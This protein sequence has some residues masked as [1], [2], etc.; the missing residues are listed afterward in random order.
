MIDPRLYTPSAARGRSVAD[1]VHELDICSCD[2]HM[3]MPTPPL[4]V[5]GNDIAFIDRRT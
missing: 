1:N 5:F 3:D 2:S 4:A